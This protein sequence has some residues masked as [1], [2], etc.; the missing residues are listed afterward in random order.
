MPFISSI[1]GNYRQGNVERYPAEKYEITGGDKVYTLGGYK[2]H[3]FTKTGISKL[4][5]NYTK[6][7]AEAMGLADASGGLVADYLVIAAGGSGGNFFSTNGNG[8]G[9]AGGYRAGSS[10][11]TTTYVQVGTG[12]GPVPSGGAFFANGA[13]S[14]IGPISSVGGGGGSMYFG[15]GQPGGSG[16]GSAANGWG[17]GSGTPGQGNPGSF[18]AYFWTGGGG[19]GSGAA[20]PNQQGGP[21]TSSSI[22]GSAVGRAG[23]G[24]GGGN[25]S[26]PGGDGFDGGGRGH[27]SCPRWP[28]FLYSF[29]VEPGCNSWGIPFGRD[30]TGGGG[31][32][33]SYWAPNIGWFQGSGYGGSGVVILKYPT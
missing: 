20:A 29:Y 1:R 18:F 4:T 12:G 33:G 14:Y 8:G 21:G 23:G 7:Y 11:F 10:P 17:A 16:G 2:I 28:Y 24:G 31:G 32:A 15:S 13:P 25:S 6:K 30:N 5:V 3:M 26:E 19:G 9:G 22:T 27:G